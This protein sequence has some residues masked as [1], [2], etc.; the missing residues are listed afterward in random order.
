[1]QILYY[2][3]ILIL[4][5]ILT[6]SKTWSQ[7][8]GLIAGYSNIGTNYGY[9]GLDA[10]LNDNKNPALNLGIGT[11]ITSTE[12]NKILLPEFHVNYKPL[13]NANFFL[14]PMTELSVTNKSFNPSVGINIFNFIKLKGGYTIPFNSETSFRGISVGITIGFGGKDYYDYMKMGF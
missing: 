5:F 7:E 8:L 14:N 10:R 11:Y 2:E 1:M 13:Q 9:F 3:K 12:G 4:I 6:V